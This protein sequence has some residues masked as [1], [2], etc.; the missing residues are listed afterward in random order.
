MS[1]QKKTKAVGYDKYVNW[2]VLIIPVVLFFGILAAPTPYGMKDVGTE[3]QLGRT[4][5]IELITQRLFHD[6]KTG[7]SRTVS[8]P[9]YFDV[10]QFFANGAYSIRFFSEEM[11]TAD[12]GMDGPAGKLPAR[13]IQ[14]V[15]NP[16]V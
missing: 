14:Y 13:R 5:V 12:D 9:D 16:I 7:F 6:F 1:D 8:C 11:K 15:K 2:K 3:Y 10:L 4:A